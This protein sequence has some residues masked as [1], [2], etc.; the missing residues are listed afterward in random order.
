MEIIAIIGGQWP[1]SSYMIPGGLTDMPRSSDLIQSRLIIARF[2]KWYETRVLG[3]SIERWQDVQSAADLDR[4]LEE[5]STHG[6]SDIGFHIQFSRHIGLDTIGGGHGNY[7]TIARDDLSGEEPV[8]AEASPT[9][10]CVPGFAQGTQIAAFDQQYIEEYVDYSWYQ[11][12][13][14]GRHPFNGETQPYATGDE[15]KK[16]SWC[17]APRYAGRP[18]E[19]G[20]LAQMVVAANPLITDMIQQHGPNVLV[21]QLARLMRPAYLIPTIESLLAETSSD[22]TFYHPAGEVIQG[23]GYGLVEATRGGLGHWVEIEEGMI[24]HYQ[25]ITPTAWNGSPRDNRDVRGPWEQ[26]L[27]GT[28]VVDKDNPVALGHV[29]RSFDACLYCSVHVIAAD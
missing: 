9:D 19:T 7:L 3:C 11:D 25:V 1:H 14:G 17:K 16:Y 28:P 4:W 8:N 13:D 22:D 20:P 23:K 24:K 6:D 27:I 18:A 15:S 10:G 5:S 12:Y 2:R 21:R 29:I 26:A